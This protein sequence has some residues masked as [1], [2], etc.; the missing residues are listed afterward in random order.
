MKWK[1]L[2]TSKLRKQ[3]ADLER[4]IGE[5]TKVKENASGLYYIFSS[6]LWSSYPRTLWG[7][8]EQLR[9]DFEE[10]DKKFDD[11]ERYLK[12]EHFSKTE[13][14]GFRKITKRSKAK[15]QP[16]EN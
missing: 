6:D 11:L 14:E 3:L 15:N 2:F 12:I 4:S 8:V 9:R 13:S 5:K 7:E 16:V 10:L 1:S